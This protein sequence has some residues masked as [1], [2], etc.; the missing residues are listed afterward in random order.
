MRLHRLG[1]ATAVVPLLPSASA[2]TARLPALLARASRALPREPA[3][4]SLATTMCT[5]ST[6]PLA[7]PVHVGTRA[8]KYHEECRLTGSA[9][10]SWISVASYLAQGEAAREHTARMAARRRPSS[11]EHVC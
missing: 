11:S 5:E 9:S 3:R 8:G 6:L 7:A 2:A 4:S 10:G 1:T